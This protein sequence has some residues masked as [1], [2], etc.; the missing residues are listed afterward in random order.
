[1]PRKGFTSP[2]LAADAWVELKKLAWI[3]SANT[4]TEI[5]PSYALTL[6]VGAYREKLQAEHAA[7]FLAE[8]SPVAATDSPQN[9]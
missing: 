1:M 3:L 7:R 9:A 5:T 2:T 4:G 6:A 8:N